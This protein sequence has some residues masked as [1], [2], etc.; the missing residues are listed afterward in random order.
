MI[1]SN[2][3]I[4]PHAAPMSALRPRQRE[5]VKPQMHLTVAPMEWSGY[6]IKDHKALTDWIM[7]P[8][9]IQL[10]HGIGQKQ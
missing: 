7:I 3:T 8:D 2:K 6:N 4:P 5:S 10:H 9:D 1:V